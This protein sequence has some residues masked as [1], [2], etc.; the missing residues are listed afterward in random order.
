MEQDYEVHVFIGLVFCGSLLQMLGNCPVCIWCWHQ[1]STQH[2]IWKGWLKGCVLVVEHL[3]TMHKALGSALSRMLLNGACLMCTGECVLLR[4]ELLV[5]SF[6]IP[7]PLFSF[8]LGTSLKAGRRN[9]VRWGVG[10][11][12]GDKITYPT[13]KADLGLDLESV[14]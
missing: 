1:L 13:V 10:N 6:N 12:L 14:F 5:L 9:N 7:Q 11:N 8:I 3:P 4:K 2:H